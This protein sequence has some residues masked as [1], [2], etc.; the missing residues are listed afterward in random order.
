MHVW[1]AKALGLFVILG[2]PINLGIR[3]SMEFQKTFFKVLLKFL[4]ITNAL[5]FELI[6][7][8][9]RQ[10]AALLPDLVLSKFMASS[11]L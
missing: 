3:I 10:C 9:I 5:T 4:T 6:L 8:N 11:R 2:N 1:F 7:A